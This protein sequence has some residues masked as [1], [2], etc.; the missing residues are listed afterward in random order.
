MASGL[1]QLGNALFPTLNEGI[2]HRGTCHV[3]R[4]GL[5]VRGSRPMVIVRNQVTGVV[6]QA[7]HIGILGKVRNVSGSQPHEVV[8]K[9]ENLR[10]STFPRQLQAGNM[11]HGTAR[12]AIRMPNGGKPF[13]TESLQFPLHFRSTIRAIVQINVKTPHCRMPRPSLQNLDDHSTF[14]VG[15]IHVQMLFERHVLTRLFVV[16]CLDRTLPLGDLQL[17]RG[18]HHSR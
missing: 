5:N 9:D 7:T 12:Q 16:G 2:L 6:R 13:H 17:F 18:K 4:G 8:L 1:Q 14:P 15:G 10:V 3:P 11:R